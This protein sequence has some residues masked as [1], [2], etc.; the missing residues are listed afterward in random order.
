[1]C[2]VSLL[3]AKA[4]VKHFGVDASLRLSGAVGSNN[5]SAPGNGGFLTDHG[6]TDY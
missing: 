4:R 3:L 5:A 2:G 1:M 6:K